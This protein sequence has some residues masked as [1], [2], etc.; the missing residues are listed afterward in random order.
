MK[1]A[2]GF[3][4]FYTRDRQV[5]QCEWLRNE[6]ETNVPIRKMHVAWRWNKEIEPH[7]PMEERQM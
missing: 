6:T 2:L 1:L 4:F 3:F 7:V 5:E